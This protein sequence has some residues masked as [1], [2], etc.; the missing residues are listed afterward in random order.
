MIFII[1]VYIQANLEDEIVKDALK[2]VFLIINYYIMF[3]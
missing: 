3:Q 2:T 1:I